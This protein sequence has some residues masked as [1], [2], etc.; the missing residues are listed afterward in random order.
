[1]GRF[2]SPDQ[3]TGG[4]LDLY[5]PNPTN[6]VPL[7]Y[8]NILNPQSLNKYSSAWNNPLRSI[9]SD[10]Y[11]ILFA[12]NLK[13]AQLVKD[14]VHAILADPNTSSSLSGFVGSDSFDLIFR[15]GDLNKG[16]LPTR[17]PNGQTLTTTIQGN[18]IP[19][20]QTTTFSSNGVTSTP[21][22]TLTGATITID[23]RTS[24]GD[25]PGVFVHESVHAGEALANPA[26][27]AKDAKAE[28][29]LPH[30]K[31]PQEQRANAAQRAFTK[32]IKKAVKRIE[33][34]RKKEEQK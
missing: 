10:G 14:T 27:F 24:K 20:F 34:E 26:Q 23:N 11:E 21:N 17:L 9:D 30:D 22:T 8:A 1:M 12:D 3:S 25:T 29:S 2:T 5:G 19:N 7:P 31:R 16:N 33:K 32:E 18:T 4:P 13:N 6:I 28:R 15:S